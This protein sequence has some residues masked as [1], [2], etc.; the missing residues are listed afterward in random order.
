MVVVA[1]ARQCLQLGGQ[2]DGGGSRSAAAGT[3]AQ[4]QSTG[5]ERSN[6]GSRAGLV[7]G[8]FVER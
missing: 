1:R 2:I 8:T 7:A 4:A 6:G 3:K 5:P